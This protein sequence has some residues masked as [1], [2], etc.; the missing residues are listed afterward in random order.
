MVTKNTVVEGIWEKESFS[1]IYNK[2]TKDY[3]LVYRWGDHWRMV[4]M[5]RVGWPAE[6]GIG[7]STRES[8]ADYLNKEGYKRTRY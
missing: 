1:K 8:A 7:F 2:N 3:R 4:V 6:G 5:T